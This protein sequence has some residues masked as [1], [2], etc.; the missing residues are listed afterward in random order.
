MNATTGTLERQTTAEA[1]APAATAG[2]STPALAGGH[3]PRLTRAQW[4]LLYGSF[5][6]SVGLTFDASSDDPFITLRYA[7][8]VVHGYGPVFNPGQ[9][10]EG[11]TSPLHLL[12]LIGAYLVPG[13]HALLK[14]KLLSLVFG[15]LSLAVATR[16]VR[17]AEFPRWGV[18]VA[19]ALLG[20]SWSLAVASANGLE[21]TLACFLTTLLVAELVTGRAL[22]RPLVA[23]L[24]GV[25]LVA[26]RP[27]GIFV[28]GCLVLASAICEPRAITLWRRCRWFVGA[29]A[30]Q[31]LIEVARLGYYGEL[32][33]NT[34]YAKRGAVGSDIHAGLG[35][36]VN[37]QP[38]VPGILFYAQ[39]AL[40]SVGAWTLARGR[41]PQR[42]WLYA[43][44]AV[45]AQVLAIIETGGDWMAGD[46]FFV[47]VAPV[48]AILL[49][50]G[51]VALTDRARSRWLPGSRTLF[52]T[53]CAGL[54][55]VMAV[56]VIMPFEEDHDPVW[57]SHGR[58][59]DASLVAAGGYRGLSDGV[60]TDGAAMLR[61]V[62]SGSLVADSEIG[63]I[64]FERPDLRILDTRG[65]TDPTI[66]HDAPAAEKS[67]TG[68]AEL[69]WSNPNSVVG[70][71]ILAAKPIAVL[72][73]DYPVGTAPRRTALGGSYLLVAERTI[74]DLQVSPGTAQ[75]GALYER[76]S[77]LERGVRV[78]CS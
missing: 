72:S 47:P 35:Y 5:L 23:G 24:A 53:F 36:L 37:L 29:L 18:N 43:S 70:A 50:K 6:I 25:G 51:A 76:A 13:S 77:Q 15:A 17:A 65:L 10:V 66:A 31:L 20:A 7:A 68:V 33:P 39:V 57:T 41:F 8:N 64:G 63:F 60:W 71:R 32:L 14:A 11:F 19:L 3:S 52:V 30:A 54:V 73:W 26:A 55:L 78:T 75:V 44:V 45:V 4:A 1:N 62:P 16:L 38:G 67:W 42:R 34:Y 40:V 27:E 59:D 69:D 56:G 22:E 61:C 46:R 58:L 48:A 9:R 12:L 74:S 28:A 2:R 49:A 21:T